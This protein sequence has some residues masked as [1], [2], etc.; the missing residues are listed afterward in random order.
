[1]DER[2]EIE[3]TEEE[4]LADLRYP[5]TGSIGDERWARRATLR[6]SDFDV[7]G[8]LRNTA[9][10]DL[11]NEARLA[12]FAEHGFALGRL[13]DLGIG[14]VI[15]AERSTYCREVR[16]GEELTVDFVVAAMA[17]DARRGTVENRI[18]KPS[19]EAAAVVAVEAGWL[20]LERRGLVA[21][22][23]AVARLLLSAPR[24]PGFEVLDA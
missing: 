13:R 21:P 15:L 22:P 11:A 19:G 9:Y 23:P 4:I 6:W 18:R 17:P 16:L 7:N 20:S 10:S 12:F 1:M 2:L 14:P 8:H 5:A 24:T 3:I